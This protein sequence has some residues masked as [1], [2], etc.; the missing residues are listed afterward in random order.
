ML[1]SCVLDD[2]PIEALSPDLPP[3]LVPSSASSDA[4]RFTLTAEELA[5]QSAKEPVAADVSTAAAATS[6]PAKLSYSAGVNL[7]FLGNIL[8]VAVAAYIH[9]NPTAGELSRR[10]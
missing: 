8:P 7:R 1:A 4:T 5:G 6:P 10:L 2:K 3:L 9:G